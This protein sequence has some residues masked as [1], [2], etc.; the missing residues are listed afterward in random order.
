MAYFNALK[1]VVRG[2]KLQYTDAL[3]AEELLTI[4]FST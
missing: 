3:Y 1:P 4:Q 2:L